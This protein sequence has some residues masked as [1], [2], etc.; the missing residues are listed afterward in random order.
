MW[1]PVELP[2][3][4]TCSPT[5]AVAACVMSWLPT[6]TRVA[7]AALELSLQTLLGLQLQV[8]EGFAAAEARKAYT[9]ARELCRAAPGP[10]L[11]PVLWGLWLFAKARSDL[12]R[13]KEMAGELRALARELSDAD[14]ALQ[15]HQALN[16]SRR[17]VHQHLQSARKTLHNLPE[18]ESRASL[19]SLIDYLAQQTDALRGST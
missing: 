14:L 8:T 9:R 13:A 4:V 5:Y 6:T 18:S 1:M 12:P 15:A 10:T 16:E 7:S 19:S 3:L 11:F 17:A 2:R